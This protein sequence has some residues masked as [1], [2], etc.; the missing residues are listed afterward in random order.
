VEILVCRTE[1]GVEVMSAFES[2]DIYYS[3]VTDR[4]FALE[5]GGVDKGS[6]KLH[7]Q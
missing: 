7:F 3:D 4:R 5:D 1:S 6:L 2:D